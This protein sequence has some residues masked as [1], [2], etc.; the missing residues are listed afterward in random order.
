MPHSEGHS[1]RGPEL[2]SRVSPRRDALILR[3]TLG[4]ILYF[5]SSSLPSACDHKAG[6][7]SRVYTRRTDK[8]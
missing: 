6:L 7:R 8:P 3:P 2:S 5:D 1:T 4:R